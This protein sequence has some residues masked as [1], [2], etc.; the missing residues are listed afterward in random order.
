[1]TARRPGVNA[2][3][4]ATLQIVSDYVNVVVAAILLFWIG[5]DLTARILSPFWE[6]AASVVPPVSWSVA[7]LAFFAVMYSAALWLQRVVARRSGEPS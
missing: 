3:P 4:T 2:I 7:Y 6:M 5:T 1:M